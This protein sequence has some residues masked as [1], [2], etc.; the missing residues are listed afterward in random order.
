MKPQYT[1]ALCGDPI[2]KRLARLST[3]CSLTCANVA[4]VRKNSRLHLSVK[5]AF[6]RMM[7]GKN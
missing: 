7:K 1:C 6:R 2:G 5:L 4:L 3:F